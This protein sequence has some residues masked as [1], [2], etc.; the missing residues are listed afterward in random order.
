VLSA[1]EYFRRINPSVGSK[2][3]LAGGD[4][5]RVRRNTFPILVGGVKSFRR[6]LEVF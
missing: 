2:T 1:F 5:Y 4:S 3:F 6:S